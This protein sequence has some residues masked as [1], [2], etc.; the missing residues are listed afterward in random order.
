MTEALRSGIRQAIRSVPE[1]HFI[2]IKDMKSR[3]YARA[4][5]RHREGRAQGL[6]IDAHMSH[7]ESRFPPESPGLGSTRGLR[8]SRR[9]RKLSATS[10]TRWC[11]PAPRLPPGRPEGRGDS[12]RAGSPSGP[13][14]VCR[15]DLRSEIAIVKQ[16]AAAV[17]GEGREEGKAH[18]TGPATAGDPEYRAPRAVETQRR[19]RRGSSPPLQGGHRELAGETPESDPSMTFTNPSP[20][21][22]GSPDGGNTPGV[23][24]GARRDRYGRGI[25]SKPY[26]EVKPSAPHS[27]RRRRRPPSWGPETERPHAPRNPRKPTAS[28]SPP[29]G[30][31]TKPYSADS[32]F[33]CLLDMSYGDTR[34]LSPPPRPGHGWDLDP[35][36]RGVSTGPTRDLRPRGDGGDGRTATVHT[37]TAEALRDDA[38]ASGIP[39]ASQDTTPSPGG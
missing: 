3:D 15:A 33:A 34:T 18:T 12:D 36:P 23:G 7:V 29:L 11:T 17:F 39:R 8:S 28:R 26:G 4:T 27:Q 35:L 2:D 31:L 1:K 13:T 21:A 32:L 6:L 24:R 38:R 16:A 20:P 19:S 5:L 37:T 14:H 22:T 9:Q 10:R 25:G 30:R